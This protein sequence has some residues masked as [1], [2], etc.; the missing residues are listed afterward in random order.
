MVLVMGSDLILSRY[1]DGKF[2]QSIHGKL[3]TIKSNFPSCAVAK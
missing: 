3:P 2:F 1:K